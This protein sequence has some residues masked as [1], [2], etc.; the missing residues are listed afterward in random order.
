MSTEML[1]GGIAVDLEVL[2]LARDE[3]HLLLLARAGEGK[4]NARQGELCFVPTPDVDPPVTMVLFDEPLFRGRG[5]AYMLQ[6]AHRRGG[7][8]SRM[9][10]DPEVFAKGAVRHPDHPTVVLR[11]WH[12]VTTVAFLD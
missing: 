10:R 3:R 7:R 5:K 1:E 11:V 2:D 12:R 8:W 6:F 9:V 4:H